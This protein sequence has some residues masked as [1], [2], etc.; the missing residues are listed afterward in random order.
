MTHALHKVADA[1]A[2]NAFLSDW[3]VA[4]RDNK[5]A[6]ETPLFISAMFPT[7]SESPAVPAS[8]R[9]RENC[10]TRRIVFGSSKIAQLKA[11]VVLESN[12]L[13]FLNNSEN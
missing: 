2:L 3:A 1:S 11:M 6:C 12:V 10:V 7:P 13:K 4:A 8:G 9:E 5:V